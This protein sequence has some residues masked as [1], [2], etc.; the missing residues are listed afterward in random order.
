MKKNTDD[1]LMMNRNF[2][3]DNLRLEINFLSTDQNKGVPAPPIEKTPLANQKIIQLASPQNIA[4]IQDIGLI[5]AIKKRKSIRDFINTSVTLD[6]IAF[7]LWATQGL[8]DKPQGKHAYRVV[9]SAGCR[10]SFETYIIALNIKGLIEGIYRYLPVEHAL[11]VE[12]QQTHL[13]EKIIQATLGQ[14][15]VGNAAAVFIWS[16]IPYRMEWRYGLAAHRV[17]AFDIGHVCQNLY[18]AVQVISAGTCAIAAYNQPLMDE[19]LGLDGMNE[20]V[21]Y[22]AA[23]GKINNE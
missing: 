10:H 9:P 8:R 15:F 7:L 3:K 13:S 2:L 1:S 23:I 22:L 14:D 4:D 12:S 17:I 6:E 5:Q 16:S 21:I 20:F 11:V 18:L 19:L